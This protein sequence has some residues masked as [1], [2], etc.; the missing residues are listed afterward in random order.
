MVLNFF[1]K[2]DIDRTF[3]VDTMKKE[4][5]RKSQLMEE[6]ADLDESKPELLIREGK[7]PKSHSQ[8]WRV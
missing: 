5:S 6:L 2:S 7:A 4:L 8:C 1:L 3:G